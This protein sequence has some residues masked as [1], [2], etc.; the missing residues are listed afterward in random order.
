MY[1]ASQIIQI[2]EQEANKLGVPPALAIATA[3]QESGLNPYAVGD[4][5]ASVGLYQLNFAGG[6]G[7]AAGITPTQAMNPAINASIAL[8]EMASVYNSEPNASPGQ[9]AVDAQR[10]AQS[11]RASYANN[12]NNLVDSIQNG[13]FQLPDINPQ[14]TVST[15][16]KNSIGSA[17]PPASNFAAGLLSGLNSAMSPSLGL[18]AWLPNK[19]ASDVRSTVVLFITRIGASLLFLVLGAIGLGLIVKGASS[20]VGGILGGG[21]NQYNR[22]AS[23][24]LT[25]RRLDIDAAREARI[26]EEKLRP[27]ITDDGVTSII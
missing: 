13:S 22:F 20:P 23:R 16:S 10:P 24:R 18:G 4:G 6:E 19:W 12:V 25:S 5:G 3:Y 7:T 21:L 2:I 8:Q 17:S 14:L 26:R 15:S 1:T 9:I 11:V 27:S